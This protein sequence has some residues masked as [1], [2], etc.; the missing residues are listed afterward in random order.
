MHEKSGLVKER[1]NAK[2]SLGYQYFWVAHK[3]MLNYLKTWREQRRYRCFGEMGEQDN[4]LLLEI[5]K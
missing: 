4:R 5:I 3:V 2:Y 1:A